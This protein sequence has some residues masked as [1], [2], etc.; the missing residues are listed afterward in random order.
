MLLLGKAWSDG[1][2]REAV[3]SCLVGTH[4]NR[5]GA[6]Q[7]RLS[8]LALLSRALWAQRW[9]S[10][11]VPCRSAWKGVTL[12]I[13]PTAASEALAQGWGHSA[14]WYIGREYQVFCGPPVPE[15]TGLCNI[16]F[17]TS[18][19]QREEEEKG[20]GGGAQDLPGKLNWFTF[21]RQVKIG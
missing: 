19:W 6:E 15:L 14:V 18:F 12:L 17:A 5:R 10:S 20:G 1:R 9:N 8:S 3:A 16:N 21:E 4:P 11:Y 13:S 7:Q 2:A